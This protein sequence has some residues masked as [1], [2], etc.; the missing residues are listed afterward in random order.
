MAP[1]RAAGEA[2][3]GRG[4]E[5]R[6]ELEELRSR[7]RSLAGSTKAGVREAKQETFRKVISYMTI[8]IDVSGLF[9]EMIMACSADDPVLKKMLY[10]YISTYAM[11]KPD[12]ALLTVNALQKDC[13][14]PDPTIRG[15]ALR[16]L[17]SLRVP[18]LV[19]YLVGPLR[20]GLEDESA[21]VRKTAA[22]GVLKLYAL[23]PGACVDAGFVDTLR[24]MVTGDRDAGVVANCLSTLVEIEGGVEGL[25]TK[26]LVYSL[27]NRIKEFSEYAQ[28]MVI[29]FV[30]AYKPENADE[31][32]AFMNLLEDR[33]SHTNSAI[34]LATTKLFLHITMEI[35]QVHQQVYERV[36]A[37][38]LTLASTA[39]PEVAFAVLSHLKLLVSRAPSLFSL[40]YKQ[41]YCRYSDPAYVKRVKLSMLAE[42]AD[43]NNVYEIVTELSEYAADIDVPIAR[44]SLHAIGSIALRTEDMGGISERLLGFLDADSPHLVSETLI[45]AKDLLRRFPERAFDILEAAAAI[46]PNSITEPAA[47]AALVWM[48]GEFGHVIPSAP[49]SL[50]PM[51]DD[52][53]DEA[54]PEVRLELLA[55][56]TK[57]FLK[58]PPECQAMLGRV[59]AAGCED[60]HM[61]VHDRALMYYRLLQHSAT[62]ASGV[63]AAPK[64]AV[65]EFASGQSQAAKDAIFE[66]FNSLSVIYNKPAAAF[67]TSD[68]ADQF[69][70]GGEAGPDE[71]AMG[72]G[73]AEQSAFAD[74]N[75]LDLDADYGDDAGG[76][77]SGAGAGGG[78]AYD[79]IDLLGGFDQP[80]APGG[81][82][83]APP[84]SDPLEDL[85]GMGGM[86]AGAPAPSPPRPAV[87]FVQGAALAPAAFQAAW[88]AME[89]AATVAGAPL[90]A[91]GGASLAGGPRPLITHLASAG[92][93][94]I[95]SGGAH[96]AYKYFLYAHCQGGAGVGGQV[97]LALIELN[98][99]CTGNAA[100]GT[101]KTEDAS[102]A[103]ACKEVLEGALMRF[104][105]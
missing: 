22:M 26:A 8:S 71:G 7:L 55:A 30:C 103:G 67:V 49:Y 42:V 32:F 19:E 15:L 81:Q 80:A 20:T 4:S 43:Q 33:M 12:L 35:E 56:A 3:P 2:A 28:C 29:D 62:D 88:G 13:A 63:I 98:V 1:A 69:G 105:G 5:R 96:P 77:P 37:P 100:S 53:A 9:T 97:S 34:V 94:C 86:G 41:F 58:R 27:L 104:V 31:V 85:L 38:L 18:N 83:A 11:R 51:L 64:D 72:G 45:V 95:A 78:T 40:D 44:A 93:N 102:L 16:S 57:L 92:V 25:A 79:P 24:A 46:P 70:A 101:I 17:G 60:E 65:V 87:T 74:N 39:S 61:D 36:K 76:T 68:P 82:A 50:E 21:Y 52:F 84:L 47:R 99:D 48:L 6:G 75:L 91:G 23:D 90:G 14:E 59:L 73:A 66:E 10:L 54:S 89:P